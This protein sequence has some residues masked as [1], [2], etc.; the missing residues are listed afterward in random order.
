MRI[1]CRRFVTMRPGA[2]RLIIVLIGV[3][4]ARASPYQEKIRFADIT[5]IPDD[6]LPAVDTNVD[7]C[8]DFYNYA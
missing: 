8:E 4:Q 7:P 2:F 1:D 3:A 5:W 6:M